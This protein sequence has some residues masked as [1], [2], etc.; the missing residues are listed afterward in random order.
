MT[1]MLASLSAVEP[2][3]KAARGPSPC[4]FRA[5]VDRSASSAVPSD[6]EASS[7]VVLPNRVCGSADG[8]VQDVPALVGQLPV[9]GAVYAAYD[10]FVLARRQRRAQGEAPARASL[11]AY[12]DRPVTA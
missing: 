3:S 11:G 10:R 8:E 4:P 1:R 5:A 7:Q 6:I 2:T 12:E 9:A